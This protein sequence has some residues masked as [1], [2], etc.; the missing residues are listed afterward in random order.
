MDGIVEKE[1][2]KDTYVYLDNVTIAGL[3][4]EEHDKNVEKFLEVSKQ[5]NLTLN[6]SKTVSSA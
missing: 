5:K 6:E 4:K 1:N 2:L 3:T